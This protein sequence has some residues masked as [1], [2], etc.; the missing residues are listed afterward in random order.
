MHAVTV[1]VGVRHAW[2]IPVRVLVGQAVAVGVFED[3]KRDGGVHREALDGVV[4]PDGVGGEGARA[5]GNAGD[6]PVGGPRKAAKGKPVGQ[7]GLDGPQVGGDAAEAWNQVHLFPNAKPTV[8][9]AVGD[10][11]GLWRVAQPVV[12]RVVGHV[13]DVSWVGAAEPFHEVGPSIA[14]VV[15]VRKVADMVAVEVGGQVDAVEG[16]RVAEVLLHVGPPVAV[17][18]VVGAVAA[19]VSV[20]VVGQA[21][22]V[23]WIASTRGLVRVRPTVAVVVEVVQIGDAVVVKVTQHRDEQPG[24]GA[25]ERVSCFHLHQEVG[26]LDAW[27]AADGSVARIEH[28]ALGQRREHRPV[29]DVATGHD[30]FVLQHALVD[31]QHRLLV[32]VDHAQRQV[33]NVVQHVAQT[34][35]VLVGGVVVGIE[36]IGAVAGRFVH[37]AP[38]VVVVVRVDGVGEAVFIEVKVGVHHGNPE[39]RRGP[40]EVV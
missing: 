33:T 11:L 19:T 12:V 9:D 28:Q 34:V 23:A 4:G 14:V 29:R 15:R 32:D 38:T 25:V 7:I 36:G 5:G 3:A 37:V 17:H 21:Q 27:G 30:G 40:V 6:H 22:R 8:T 2:S 18:V 39:H 10:A 31:R 1:V 24:G 20:H 26:P 35:P 16:I 13:E